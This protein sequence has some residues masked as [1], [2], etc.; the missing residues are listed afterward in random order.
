MSE[1]DSGL[2]S[3]AGKLALAFEVAGTPKSKDSLYSTDA[4][5]SPA[6]PLRGP[7]LWKLSR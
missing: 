1:P 6:S 7:S 4:V 2:P 3:L 5:R